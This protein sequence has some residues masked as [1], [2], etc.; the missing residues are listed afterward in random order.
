[1]RVAWLKSPAAIFGG[2]VAGVLVGLYARAWARPLEQMGE[3]YLSFLMM[4]VV[5][6]MV[7][8]LVSSLAR[9]IS[10]PGAA[11]LIRRTLLVFTLFLTG[12]AALVMLLGFLFRPGD[13]S[14]Q[15]RGMMGE[16]LADALTASGATGT[17]LTLIGFL[18]GLVPA[19]LFQAFAVD[20]R[21][22]I[23]FFS[24]LFGTLLGLASAGIKEQL[25]QMVE[26]IF[27]L[28]QSAISLA[29]YGLP[30]ALL[31]LT[32]GSVA[33]TGPDLLLAMSRF[34]GTIWLA[35]LALV[36][37]AMLLVAWQTRT[38]LG[39]QFRTLR[40][41]WIMAFGTRSSTATMPLMLDLLSAAWRLHRPTVNL[42]V[43][44][45]VLICRYGIV[46][47]SSLAL[48]FIAQLYFI[49]LGPG[50]IALMVVGAALAAVTTAGAPAVA[51]LSALALVA[52]PLGLPYG[53]ALPLLTAILPLIDPIMTVATVTLNSAATAL[54]AGP[55]TRHGATRR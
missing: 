31:G 17:P 13:L 52:A 26:L 6:I 24:I 51:S 48:L 16:I 12:V 55:Q 30:F 40:P 22:Q 50:Q 35:A 20:N 7:S 19:N 28:F 11:G 45:G 49:P 15:A 2:L 53:A 21:L 32:A 9:L 42:V 18:Q 47:L 37:L 25:I 34:I 3:V 29:M 4:C 23:L 14:S 33:R 8:A 38:P 41:V 27:W 46:M 10:T 39:L 1:M 43:P 54:I 44:L 36:L 5:P